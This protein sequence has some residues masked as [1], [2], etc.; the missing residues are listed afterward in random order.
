MKFLSAR[1]LETGCLELVV[2]RNDN[3]EKF[4]P[5]LHQSGG[6]LVVKRRGNDVIFSRHCHTLLHTFYQD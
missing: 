6:K 4:S 5:V 2:Q 1:L 3:D